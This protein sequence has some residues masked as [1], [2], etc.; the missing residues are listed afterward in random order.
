MGVVAVVCWF[1]LP[2]EFVDGRRAEASPVHACCERVVRIS[3][4]LTV[5][6]AIEQ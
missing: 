5:H 1:M 2:H 3:V 4:A 6:D